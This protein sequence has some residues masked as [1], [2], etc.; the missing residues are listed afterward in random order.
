MEADSEFT[1]DFWGSLLV[2]FAATAGDVFEE[3]AE[4]T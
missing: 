1:A 3:M 2:A 4:L